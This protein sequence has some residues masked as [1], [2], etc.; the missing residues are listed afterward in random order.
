MNRLRRVALD[1]LGLLS[2]LLCL[3]T[4]ALW[5]R[6][7][8]TMDLVFFKTAGERRGS[9][10]FIHSTS[11]VLRVMRVSEWPDQGMNCWL[12]FPLPPDEVGNLSYPG[13]HIDSGY[14]AT[15]RH[16]R[17]FGLNGISQPMQRGRWY[18]QID[19][20]LLPFATILCVFPLLRVLRVVVRRD[21]RRRRNRRKCCPSCGY[22]LRAT[23]ERCPECGRIAATKVTL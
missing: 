19:L 13:M 3:G 8:R 4:G 22:D 7:F 1:G 5:R 23:L 16:W 18:T 10:W 9:L 2:L 17:V 21:I 15:E 14:P 11:G 6:S 20:P 12:S